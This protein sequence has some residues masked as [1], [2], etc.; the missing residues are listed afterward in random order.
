M[1]RTQYTSPLLHVN[2]YLL[3]FTPLYQYQHLLHSSTSNIYNIISAIPFYQHEQQHLIHSINSSTRNIHNSNDSISGHVTLNV[4]DGVDNVVDRVKVCMCA[5]IYICMWH[6]GRK[7]WETIEL[8][9]NSIRSKLI[10]NKT[11]IN[12]F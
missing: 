10:I 8:K 9:T 12:C 4:V 2:K 1:H 6:K 3:H 5:Y 11:K 7:S